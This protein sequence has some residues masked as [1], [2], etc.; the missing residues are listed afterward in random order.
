M[1]FTRDPI[2]ETIITPKE[3]NALLVR[4][5]KNP[6][7]DDYLVD[8]VELV[9]FG[10]GIFFRS[11]EKPKSFLLPV[12]DYEVVEVKEAK[13]VLKNAVMEKSIKIGGGKQQEKMPKKSKRRKNEK[14][15]VSINNEEGQ[16]APAITRKLIPPPTTLIKQKIVPVKNP[17]SIEEN[18][19]PEE[20]VVER[21][22]EASEK[23]E[24]RV[25]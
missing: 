15:A 7:Q 20:V 1:H 2:I 5:S 25:E 12:T 9:N 8:C 10:G 22:Q 21:Q 4:N 17:E 18:A 6:S 14:S 13:M 19:L 16:E 24:E 23:I 11:L 3:G